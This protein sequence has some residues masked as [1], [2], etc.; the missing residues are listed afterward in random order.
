MGTNK[1]PDDLKKLAENLL[2]SDITSDLAHIKS[3]AEGLISD[4]NSLFALV[5]GQMTTIFEKPRSLEE[6]AAYYGVACDKLILE[7]NLKGAMKYVGGELHISLMPDSNKFECAAELYFQDNNG[8]WFQR[9]ATA[10]PCALACLNQS[11]EDELLKARK[12]SFEVT[13]PTGN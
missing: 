11:A 2:P 3:E 13:P 5:V 12:V 7:E 4:L 9:T 10:T 6:V 8:K 1:I